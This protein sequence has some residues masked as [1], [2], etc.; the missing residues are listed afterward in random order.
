MRSADGAFVE[1]A[2]RGDAGPRLRNGRLVIVFDEDVGL[3]RRGE[4]QPY[5]QGKSISEERSMGLCYERA[6]TG[7]EV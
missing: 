4:S 1:D 7:L 3:P 6:T 2:V 5:T